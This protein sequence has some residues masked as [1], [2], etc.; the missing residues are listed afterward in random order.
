MVRKRKGQGL[1]EFALVLPILLLILL[2]II[3]A[4]LVI[5]GHLAVQH[6]AREA[7]R[8]AITYQPEQGAC[9]DLDKDGHINGIG[10]SDP[11]D[12]APYPNCPSNSPESDA[13]YYARRIV[14]IKRVARERAAGLRVNLNYL[15]DTQQRFDDYKGEP[16][17]FG[18]L[19]WGYPSF[20]TDCN[21]N[22]ALCL[23]HPGIE[24]LP[25]RI[26]VRH[27][28]EILD[29]LY[30]V[31]AKYVTVQAEAQMINEGVQV[32][33]GNMPP[34]DFDFNPDP[35]IPPP[36]VPTSSSGTPIPTALPTQPPTV[37]PNYEIALNPEQATNEMPADRCHD[38]VATVTYL[39]QPVLSARV[40]FSTTVGG[41]D[42]SGIAN[43]VEALTN[44]AGQATTTICGNEPMTAT[45]RTW[46]DRD[47]NDTWNG[48]TS[49]TSQKVWHFTGP[50]ITVVDHEVV[51][52]DTD[53]ANVM[54][55]NPGQYSLYWC[56][57]SGTNTSAMVLDPVTV[58]A[59]RN[60]K[61]L[62]FT[63]PD[64]SEGLYRLETHP[65]GG[66]GCGAGDL[67]AY[68]ADIW[69]IPA[70]PDLT[71]ASF[72]LPPTICPRTV[73]T[74]SAVVQN[75]AKGSTDEAFDVDFYTGTVGSPPQSPIGLV[76]QWVA[77]ISR[78]GAVTVNAVMWVGSPGTHTIWAR[79]DTSD[80]VA[81]DY[82]DNNANSVTF[83]TGPTTTTT[84]N[85]DWRS[86]TANAADTGGDGNG[87]ETNPTYAY[88]NDSNRAQSIDTCGTPDCT[89]RHRYYDFN[90]PSIPVS[91]TILGVEV[92]LHW[93]LDDTG[94]TNSLGADLSWN[95]GANW[96]TP[97]KSDTNET[98][99]SSG[100]RQYTLGSTGD[101][102]G[103]TW[104]PGDFSNGNFRVRVN[105]SATSDNTRDFS[106]DW[107][108]V[109]V[110]YRVPPLCVMGSDP[111]P[112]GGDIGKPPGLR[113]CQQPT[114]L[115][116]G[117]FEGNVD[118]V[119]SYWY[120]GGPNGFK[121]QS[122]YFYEG[123][124]SLRLHTTKGSYPECS[125]VPN[126]YLYQTVQIPNEVYT[127][128]TMIVRGQRLV[129]ENDEAAAGRG[130]C[131][132]VTDPNDIL[133]MKMR[134]GSHADLGSGVQIANGGVLTRTWAPFEIDVTGVVSPYLRHGQ[135]V[136]VY[137]YGIQNVDNN[138]TFFYLDAL[139]CDVC[140]SWPI[141][142]D[143]TGTASFGGLV[144]VLVQGIPQTRQGINVWAYSPGGQ[145]YNTYT[146]QDGTYHFYNV[147]PG[148]YTIYAEFWEGSVLHYTTRTVT[149]TA[150]ERNYGVELHMS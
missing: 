142:T 123:T 43:Y 131:Y 74:M 103:R 49:D 58:D 33:F 17:F 37:P 21:A 112:W 54:N 8:F 35:D 48:E 91:A 26:L 12:V 105:A 7:A 36:V 94:G 61:N 70:L 47:G 22:P 87:F 6:A 120:A 83:T 51:A 45:L 132:P 41:F 146:I 145:V 100:E 27:N 141:P 34:P 40:S 85:T 50:Y 84:L 122:N 46:V 59:T 113:E 57:V 115:R 148:T 104:S 4:A 109:R 150:N 124:L 130:C 116:Y 3:E 88:S 29:P 98:R 14:L 16:G 99:C 139:Q 67:V 75:L 1:V 2:G 72:T 64:D 117:G 82:E 108:G 39:G 128:T 133:Y 32:G 97:V 66:G 63:V 52:L 65:R 38:F 95:G 42:F 55:H 5:Q 107:V 137:F 147:P 53:S 111:S 102:W 76:K 86:P 25:V 101:T 60:A 28:V 118:R 56:V 106:L 93:C 62:L 126:P 79:A 11:D 68:S 143:I 73:F 77:G 119:F 71:I 110:T 80:Y 149:V 92:Q 19:V 136:D 125:A 15:G 78:E 96:T 90:I 13:D 31:I 140:T 81:E 20:Q 121:R 129:A 114:L 138:C 9:M 134:D 23:D 18:V 24:G 89:E 69:V 30:R 127:Q 44:A 144:Q 135:N 10:S